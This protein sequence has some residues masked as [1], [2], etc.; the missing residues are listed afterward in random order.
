MSVD[1]RGLTDN[2]LRRLTDGAVFTLPFN[3][4]SENER[5]E[6]VDKRVQLGTDYLVASFEPNIL[7]MHN[8]IQVNKDLPIDSDSHY[9]VTVRVEDIDGNVVDTFTTTLEDKQGIT[10][11]TPFVSPFPSNKGT[12]LYLTIDAVGATPATKI[13]NSDLDVV[14][15]VGFT[16]FNLDR[17]EGN[18]LG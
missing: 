10:P 17:S 6:G 2:N 1:R 16:V 18:Y 5:L 14:V 12:K 9:E 11:L 8:V 13:P 4:G 15:K 7:L 3:L